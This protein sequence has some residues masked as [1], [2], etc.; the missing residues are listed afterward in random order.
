MISR[1]AAV[2]GSQPSRFAKAT[3]MQWYTSIL[4]WLAM[5]RARAF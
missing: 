2:M 3:E 4:A 5:P 1:A